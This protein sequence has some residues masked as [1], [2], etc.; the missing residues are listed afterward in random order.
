MSR[1]TVGD[2]LFEYIQKSKERDEETVKMQ[3]A[4]NERLVAILN[5]LKGNKR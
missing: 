4:T 2:K 5:D 3:I 1:Q